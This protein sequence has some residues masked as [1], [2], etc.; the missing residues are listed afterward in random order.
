[1]LRKPFFYHFLCTV[2][3]VALCHLKRVDV[4][5]PYFLHREHVIC[6][7][8]LLKL[9]EH[10]NYNPV[11]TTNFRYNSFSF[12]FCLQN[13]KKILTYANILSFFIIFHIY[14]RCSN[15]KFGVNIA[16]A[17]QTIT[18]RSSNTHQTI[19]AYLIVIN[20][21]ISKKITFICRY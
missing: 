11:K 12:Q 5:P 2:R 20:A 18:K 19:E 16:N 3:K 14:L 10:L 15:G 21:K 8:K 6:G 4:T 17:H 1:M 7:F 9:K 13:Y